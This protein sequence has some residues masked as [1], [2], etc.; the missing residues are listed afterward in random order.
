[1]QKKSS[2]TRLIV[3]DVDGTLVDDDQK[4]SENTINVI[5]KLQNKGLLISLATGKIYPS[6]EEL[7]NL[8]NIRAPIILANGA[9]I[10][11]PNGDL[12]SGT[13]LSPDVL[14]VIIKSNRKFEADLALF[15]PDQIFVERETFNTDHIKCVFKEKIQ[16]IID[17]QKV[18]KYFP[19]VCKT[20]L[21]NRNDQEIIDSLTIYLRESLDGKVTLSTGAPNSVETMPVG[22]SKKAGLLK[23]VEYLQISIEEVMVFGDQI[24]DFGMI[25]IA[26]VGVAVGN[27]IDEV[28]NISDFVIGTNNQE[29]PANFLS[30]YFHLI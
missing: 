8:L 12:I 26:G 25:E 27:A 22:V 19:V 24:N 10:Q 16:A 3:F 2:E 29:G 18:K 21:I 1:M 7:L 13:F 17:W 28:K 15:T 20:I 30:E 5:R 14:D 9:I 4:L 23:L 6:V 11:K